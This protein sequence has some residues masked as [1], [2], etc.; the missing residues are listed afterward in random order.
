MAIVGKHFPDNIIGELVK[1]IA[2]GEY[3]FTLQNIKVN[4]IDMSAG[5]YHVVVD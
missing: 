2:E 1:M 3:V 5:H 4:T